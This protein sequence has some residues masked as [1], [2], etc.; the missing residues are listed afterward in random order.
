MSSNNSVSAI[1]KRILKETSQLKQKLDKID[2]TL[3]NYNNNFNVFKHQIASAMKNQSE[4]QQENREA[5]NTS[6]KNKKKKETTS[7]ATQPTKKAKTEPPKTKN[8]D[9]P[10]CVLNELRPGLKYTVDQTGPIHAATFFARIKVDGLTYCGQGSSK[11][12]AKTN[13]AK[14][15][16]HVLTNPPKTTPTKTKTKNKKVQ[17]PAMVLNQLYPNS[18]YTCQEHKIGFK[19]TITIGEHKFSGAGTSKKVAKKAA[20]ADALAK[21]MAILKSPT[22]KQ[23]S[24][25]VSD[26]Q[27]KADYIGRIV[28][29]KFKT[30]MGNSDHA[31]F[32]VL[33]GIVMMQKDNLSS[34][35]V[36]SVNTGTKCIPGEHISLSGVTL[37]D[38]HAE[39]LSRRGLINFFYDQLDLLAGSKQHQSIFT[40][41]KDGNGY[42]LKDGNTSIRG[43]LR[44]K[45]EASEG[46]S[47]KNRS[48]LQTWDG[49]LGGE[50]LLTMSCSDKICKWNVVGLQGA[51]LSHFIEPI[52]LKSIILGSLMHETHLYRAICGRIESEVTGLPNLFQL[53][54]PSLFLLTSRQTR[55]VGKSPRLSINWCLSSPQPEIVRTNTGKPEG[56]NSKLC[57][58]EF[59]IKFMNTRGKIF[60]ITEV[61]SKSLKTYGDIKEAASSYQ[62][63]KTRLYEAF[64]KANLGTWISKPTEQD[65]F[66]LVK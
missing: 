19:I 11:K 20:A 34:C 37:N 36:I 25:S 45:I 53:N 13:A 26:D 7:D 15:A 52:Y 47:I 30:L 54:K 56:G 60:S 46:T 29:E 51:L 18:I 32:K 35:K 38:M 1:L 3:E 64:I 59:M 17:N 49:I 31:N 12:I 43:Q 39:I 42:K 23:L 33:A 55:D 8:I 57:K 24:D 65:M 27:K 9:N 61:E 22:P 66:Q 6:S 63:A 41:R 5:T 50:N 28:H 48:A 40:L 2:K 44:V 14:P 58:R 10:I 21:L 16:V 4:A 62:V